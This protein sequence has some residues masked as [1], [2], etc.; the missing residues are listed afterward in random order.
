LNGE[1]YTNIQVDNSLKTTAGVTIT[2]PNNLFFRLYGDITK[3]KGVWQATF[4][5]FA[6]FRND[7]LSFGAEASYKSNLDLTEGHNV[8]GISATGS[9]FPNKKFE[10]FVRFDYSASVVLP[11]EQ[12][13][14][15]NKLD[16]SYLLTGIQ[17]NI[18]TNIKLALNYRT[19]L[20]YNSDI[21]RTNAIYMNALFRF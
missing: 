7:L 21:Q 4:V 9:L 10:Y 8:W 6:G 17:R 20:P 16:G 13:P 2:T 19:Y 11:G 18:S 15:D 12:L 1:G 3:P 5:T 14:W